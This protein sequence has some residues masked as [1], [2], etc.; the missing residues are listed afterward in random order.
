M[1]GRA[2]RRFE[3]DGLIR[4][5]A[6]LLVK[7]LTKCIFYDCVCVFSRAENARLPSQ[8]LSTLPDF[9]I[10]EASRK[11]LVAFER[12]RLNDRKQFEKKVHE[13]LNRLKVGHKLFVATCKG[14]IIGRAWVAET[15]SWFISEVE[16][17]EQMGR[18]SIMIF[19]CTTI[20]AYRGQRVYP[21]M[22][23]DISNRYLD[24]QKLI[25]CEKRNL[26]SRKAIV[27]DFV[28]E[29]ELYLLKIFGLRLRWRRDSKTFLNR[30]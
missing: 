7:L 21:S 15:D 9:C 30:K 16:T 20:P 1:Y 2:V 5:S 22:L 10:T 12:A 11:N 8:P 4:G 29:K 24:R 25:Y 6:I 27:R 3:Q 23:R 13:G 18:G 28:L 19:D 17:N 26:S 14:Q